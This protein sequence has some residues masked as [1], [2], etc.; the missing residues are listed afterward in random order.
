[1][2]LLLPP[3]PR[4]DRWGVFLC[5]GTYFV[6]YVSM[7]YA[8]Y[9]YQDESDVFYLNIANINDIW[10]E[11]KELTATYHM[12]NAIKKAIRDGKVKK[13][14]IKVADPKNTYLRSLANMAVVFIR[15]TGFDEIFT[16]GF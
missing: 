4:L 7:I 2:S 15:G 6:D 9:K 12:E 16:E 11:Y 3:A 1:M 10:P 8:Q 13:F 14:V 5:A